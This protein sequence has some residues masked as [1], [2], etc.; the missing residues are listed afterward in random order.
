MK[1]SSLLAMLLLAFAGFLQAEAIKDIKPG[2]W[3]F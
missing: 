2:L 1:H 3:V